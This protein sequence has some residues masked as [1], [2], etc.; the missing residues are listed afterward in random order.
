MLRNE[1]CL[2]DISFRLFMGFLGGKRPMLCLAILMGLFF[3]RQYTV[4]V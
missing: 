4:T 1:K 2:N 3:D